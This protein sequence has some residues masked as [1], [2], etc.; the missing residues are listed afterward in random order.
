[1]ALATKRKVIKENIPHK[2]SQGENVTLKLNHTFRGGRAAAFLV[3]LL[4]L[5]GAFV[6]LYSAGTVDAQGV[7]PIRLVQG[8]D[9]ENPVLIPYGQ[10]G[11]DYITS[12]SSYSFAVK[13]NS[14][15]GDGVL[16]SVNIGGTQFS[17]TYQA[18][19]YSYRD[20]NGAQDYLSN[21]LN[22]QG[23]P[24]GNSI[25][26]SGAFPGV[27]LKYFALAGELK[28][29]YILSAL[30]RAPAGYL[31]SGVTL[32]FGGYVKFPGLNMWVNGTQVTG[33]T[34]TTSSAIY[35]KT[36][37]GLDVYHLP[38][39]VAFDANGQTVDLQ[40][41]VKQQ[42]QQIWFYVRTPYAWL[43]TA[44]YPVTVDPSVIVGTNA[45]TVSTT[46]EG[47]FNVTMAN[48]PTA[49]NTL[50]A[51]VYSWQ[52]DSSPIPT[53]YSIIQTGV[54]W[55]MA[56]RKTYSGYG[57]QTD[58]WYGVIG[59]GASKTVSINMTGGVT[60]DAFEIA[61]ICEW[62]GLAANPVDKTIGT[63]QWYSAPG[64]RWV[65]TG[66]TALTTQADELW[67]GA[68]GVFANQAQQSSPSE[69]FTMLD[70]AQQLL[71]NG[72]NYASLS[73]LYS[74]KSATGQA[75]CHTW[76]DGLTYNLISVGVMVTFK[77]VVS[78][79]S[80]G[81]SAS[82]TIANAS[83]TFNATFNDPQALHAKGQ[84]AF[85]TNNTGPWVWDDPV[86]FTSTPQTVAI[87]KTL[88]STV[89]ANV[90]YCFNYTNNAGVSNTTGVQYLTTTGY[91]VTVSND[92]YSVV[93]PNTTVTVPYGGSQQYNFSALDGYEIQNVIINGSIS[94]ATTSPL[95]ISNIT[96]PTTLAISTSLIIYYVTTS[97]DDGCTLLPDP[98][99]Y[100]V[101]YGT[102]GTYIVSAKTGYSLNRFYINGSSVSL[103]LLQNGNTF[104]F[105][106]SGNTTLSFTSYQ[107]S[108]PDGNSN[109][110]PGENDNPTPTPKQTIPPDFT[111]GPVVDWRET[112]PGWSV[113]LIV[114]SLV[115]AV[116][117]AIVRQTYAK[118]RGHRQP[119][120]VPRRI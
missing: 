92:A 111:P 30:P 56:Y 58:I 115:A 103:S 42:G 83:T 36:A 50:I 85:G 7:S 110:G 19:D 20:V 87:Q 33:N 63:Y 120:S 57:E 82:T 65:D 37:G 4:V 55:N 5:S 107:N 102:N 117:V 15:Y 109:P 66:T 43:Q 72:G 81:L 23:T 74:I 77:A 24:S 18:Q 41:E 16:Y 73:Y 106:P 62:S 67:I 2:L 13:R 17:L 96:G 105:M 40:Y 27:T 39:P 71:P 76:V 12:N 26:F 119:G 25:S 78:P 48:T 116:F 22:V 6:G 95:I 53:V 99:V 68:I 84:Y 21:I 1:L 86:N 70:G 46:A 34:I 91:D 54:T 14:N 11:Y 118:K 112:L 61:D 47:I 93:S 90:G 104:N 28:E 101:P 80:Y 75:F 94:A 31:T 108:V 44:A 38:K 113:W 60:N 51:A 9:V 64:G 29:H 8:P 45:K 88:N 69:G 35:F 59:A 3:L 89:G 10:N 49:G 79:Y 97:A 114:G 52:E 32:D 100:A 98:G